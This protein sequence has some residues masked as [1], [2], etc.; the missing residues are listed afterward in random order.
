MM[1]QPPHY[2]EWFQL[3]ARLALPLY[4]QTKG[5]PD[6]ETEVD[7]EWDG[8]DFQIRAILIRFLR[9]MAQGMSL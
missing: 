1:I 6:E 8:N 2:H 4:G 3:K 5:A 9:I 7:V